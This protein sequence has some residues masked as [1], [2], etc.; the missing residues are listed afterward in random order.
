MLRGFVSV[1]CASFVLFPAWVFP[2]LSLSDDDVVVVELAGVVDYPK[3]LIIL[4]ANASLDVH[5]AAPCRCRCHHRAFCL[6][7]D[8][9]QLREDSS[10][11]R[12]GALMTSCLLQAPKVDVVCAGSSL[13]KTT[14]RVSLVFF[15]FAGEAKGA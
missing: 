1:L 4:L 13:K 5:T 14:F 2:G 12:A 10:F 6:D 15:F 3:Q 7:I 8:Q 11:S 9:Y